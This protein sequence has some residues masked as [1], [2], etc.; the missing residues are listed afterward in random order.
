MKKVLRARD[1]NQDT[2]WILLD[3]QSMCITFRKRGR[4][5][6]LPVIN[7]PPE[8]QLVEWEDYVHPGTVEMLF[9]EQEAG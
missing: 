6:Q 5:I 7:P 8:E 4:N 1:A 9:K 2:R 3:E